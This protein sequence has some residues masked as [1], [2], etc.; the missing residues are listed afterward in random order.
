MTGDTLQT[1]FGATDGTLQSGGD[2]ITLG[3]ETIETLH[4]LGGDV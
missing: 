2:L 3:V 1:L 4:T